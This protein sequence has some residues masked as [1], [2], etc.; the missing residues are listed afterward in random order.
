MKSGF[1]DAHLHAFSK[2]DLEPGF[3]MKYHNG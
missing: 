1:E 2:P 3:L